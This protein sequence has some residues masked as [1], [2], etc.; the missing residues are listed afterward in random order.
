[1]LRDPQSAL[2][3]VDD[4]AESRTIIF[5]DSQPP[6][7]GFEGDGYARVYYIVVELTQVGDSLSIVDF[8]QVEVV[9]KDFGSY[10][11]VG[12]LERAPVDG[13][14]A[15][16]IVVQAAH[17]EEV[18]VMWDETV[19]FARKAI[20]RIGLVGVDDPFETGRELKVVI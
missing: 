11:S 20:G 13:S 9:G 6:D 12:W 5:L 2:V 3:A 16:H 1:M 15:E 17:G 14:A 8:G 7:A 10:A 18:V 19:P 4:T